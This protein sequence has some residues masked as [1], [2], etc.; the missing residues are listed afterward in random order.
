MV[1]GA[2]YTIVVVH[3]DRGAVPRIRPLRRNDDGDQSEV[4]EFVGPGVVNAKV[5]EEIAR[6]TVDALEKA[7]SL[8][9]FVV[10]PVIVYFRDNFTDYELLEL[11][12]VRRAQGTRGARYSIVWDHAHRVPARRHGRGGAGHAPHPDPA[13]RAGAA[14]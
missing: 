10:H 13:R 1:Y 2:P 7:E 14:A 12:Q 5:G 8:N 11:S 9:P 6:G 3:A 4:A